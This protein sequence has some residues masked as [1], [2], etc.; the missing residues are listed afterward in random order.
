MAIVN[1]KNEIVALAKGVSSRKLIEKNLE[2]ARKR[3]NEAR[4]SFDSISDEMLKIH[5]QLEKAEEELHKSREEMLKLS[6]Q[7]QTMD[8]V[9]GEGIKNRGDIETFLIGGKEHVIEEDVGE[10]R[11][12]PWNDYKKNA[13]I[14]EVLNK[15]NIER[16]G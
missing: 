9:G 3:Y 13:S 12:V 2:K 1:R 6:K 11:A 7:I 10:V 16:F 4:K 5:D 14:F 8:L 15:L